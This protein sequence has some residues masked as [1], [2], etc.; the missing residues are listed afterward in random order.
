MSSVGDG[1]LP[2]SFYK[3]RLQYLQGMCIK[4]PIFVR[5]YVHY[6]CIEGLRRVPNP[7][8]DHSALSF[9][10]TGEEKNSKQT[11]DSQCHHIIFKAIPLPWILVDTRRSCRQSLSMYC[12]R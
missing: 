3:H 10:F 4:R 2:T 5:D 7:F 9:H 6:V 1:T 8:E 12:L 11:I